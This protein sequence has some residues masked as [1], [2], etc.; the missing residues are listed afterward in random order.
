MPTNRN[1]CDVGPKPMCFGFSAAVFVIALSLVSVAEARITQLQV[2][3]LE[4]PTFGG[5]TFGTVGAYEKITARASGEV[6]PNLPANALITDIQFAPRNARGMVEYSTDVVI[7]KPIDPSKGSGKIFYDVVNRGNNL[8]Y[9]T[10][11]QAGAPSK[12]AN[13]DAAGAGTGLLMRR[14]YTLVWSGWEDTAIIGTSANLASASLPIARNPDGS[15]IV[16]NMIVEQIFDNATG[17]DI[18]LP[19]AAA[20][21]DQSQAYMVVHNHTQFVGGPLV[22]R[23]TVPTSVW[24]YVNNTTVRINRA[25][26]FL[27]PYDQGAA[28]EFVFPAK[29]PIVEGLGFA[30]TRDVI[31][32]LKHDTS[33]QNPVRNAIQYALGRGDS[34]SGRYLKGFL[35]WGFNAD[36]SGQIV[37]EGM[38]PHISGAHAIAANDRFGDANATGRSYQRHLSAK[39]E[40][41]FTY[42]VRADPFTHAVDGILNRCALNNTCPKIMHTDSGNEPY[43]KPV[44]LI[45]TD[46]PGNGVTPTDI[47]LPANVRLYTIGNSQHGPQGS[48]T[49]TPSGTCQQPGNPNQWAPHVRALGIAL[50]D[51]VTLG[52]APPTSRY[53]RVDDGTLVH[54]LPQ[55]ELGFPVIPGV[56]YTGWYNPVDELDKSVLP[57]MPIPG[58]SYTIL[59]P[60]TDSDGNSISGIRTP[61]VQVPI[62]TYTGWALRRAPF[63]ANEDCALTGQYIPFPVTRAQRL[64]T[65]DPRLSVE[66][67]YGSIGNYNFR[68]AVAV[69]QMMA[70]RTLL[71]E[72][73]AAMVNAAVARVR[74]LLPLQPTNQA[75]CQALATVQM[76]SSQFSLPTNGAVVTSATFVQATDA[77]NANSEYCKVTGS[78]KPVDTSAPDI[79]FQVNLPSAWN[80]KA[81][82]F[83]GGGY[84]GRIPNTLAYPD[85]GSRSIKTPLA[86]GYITYADDSGHQTTDTNDASFAVNDEALNNFA[87]MHVKKARDAMAAL[88]QARYGIAPKRVY[89]NGGS[90]GGREGLTGALRFPEAFDGI[91]SNYPTANFM[92]LRLWGAV[93]AHAVYDNNSA[94][95][96]TPTMVNKIASDTLGACD[97]LD[98]AADALVSNMAACRAISPAYR[99]AITC[100]NGETGYPANCL[101]Q[102]QL[103]TIAVYHEGYSLPYSLA[104]NIS[105]YTGYNALE[106]ITMELGSQAAYTNPVIDG[107]NAHHVA[108][109]DQF[110]KYFVTRDPN[111]NLLNFD[112]IHPGVWQDRIV[113]LSNTIDATNP[114]LSAF[115]AKG[116][117]ILL[118]QGLDDPSVSPYANERVYLNIRARMGQAATD[119]FMR[120]YFVPGL[121]HGNGKYL[122]N[123]DNL[124]ILDSW[125]ENGVAP[126]AVPI[127]VDGNTGASRSRPVCVYPTWPKYVGPGSINDAANYV[128]V[129]S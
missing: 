78:I 94:G 49:T 34:E 17:T 67:R 103:G 109:A 106:G 2:V 9:A 46:G 39:M 117:K 64:A 57:N 54:S 102:A 104:N 18:P 41:P 100:Q 114:D 124:N 73:G 27:A 53:A 20:N 119:S 12:T 37:F 56:T 43:L 110:V 29:D 125:V 62:A 45:T 60:K 72:D 121:A 25:D 105:D 58:Q 69:K 14:G 47:V 15:S 123:W 66:E 89:W 129:S 82:A 70:D 7:V 118:M 79:K 88:S 95:W 107:L 16:A 22:N 50:D 99:A 31:S 19:F 80:L 116:G 59:V 42:E 86:L 11:N 10:F 113:L 23:V 120:F 93:L 111:F 92:G 51:W 30:A 4:S 28:F 13:T 8:S 63:A 24:S 83:G 68:Y 75:A 40:F 3:R 91:I 77:G 87:Y 61:D 127:S 74:P 32:F 96:I 44:S 108:R 5:M 128:C 48:V 81:L 35:Y 115:R 36:E 112:A 85:L 71:A 38:N 33:T 122:I 98:G 84:D 76:P 1:S 26:P 55:S 97:T 52:I 65:G 90:T 6:D 126:P 101:T 21:L